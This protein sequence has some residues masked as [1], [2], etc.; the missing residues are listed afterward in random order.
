M[1]AP[2][3]L[4][5]IFDTVLILFLVVSPLLAIESYMT[6]YFFLYFQGYSP[7][8]YIHAF[9]NEISGVLRPILSFFLE[10]EFWLFFPAKSQRGHEIKT[11][12]LGP[13]AAKFGLWPGIKLFQIFQR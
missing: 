12:I 5:R 1:L 10:T 3:P 4:S 7:D 2:Q 9:L 8:H 6:K 13:F 11:E